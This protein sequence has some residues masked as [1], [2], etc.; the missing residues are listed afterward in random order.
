MASV[1]LGLVFESI[2]RKTLLRYGDSSKVPSTAQSSTIKILLTAQTT[3]F[4]VMLSSDELT[5]IYIICF[6]TM[7][8][9]IF[10]LYACVR[11]AYTNLHYMLSSDELTHIYIICFRP[12]SLHIFTLYAFVRWAYTYL[13]YMLSS[14]EQFICNIY[15]AIF[16]YSP[17]LDLIWLECYQ[18][19]TFIS[20]RSE[21][22]SQRTN[23][24]T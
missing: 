14:D 7:S 16:Q 19:A 21:L 20:S 2:T 23:T 11:W 24:I 15:F 12:M 10:T 6:R 5:H 13:H 9:H 8:L 22:V 3:L 4:S 17:T 18:N 1:L